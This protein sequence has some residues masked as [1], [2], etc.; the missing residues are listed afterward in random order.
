MGDVTIV[1]TEHGIDG[2]GE[3]GKRAWARWK[4]RVADL[5]LG[6]TIGFSYRLPRSPKF[7]KLFFAML[8]ALT[9]S[10][11]QFEQE[12]LR[13]WLIVGAGYCDFVPGP[14]GRMVA[15]PKSMKWESMDD[16]EFREL[17]IAI[18]R[19]IRTEHAQ[20]FLWPMAT[21]QARHDGVERLLIGWEE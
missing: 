2:L 7:H 16:D 8:G 21:P 17:V 11:E 9:D 10:Q 6:E 3:T 20:Q 5:E 13:A 15:L 18:W 4:Q 14:K 19:F 1:K 12:Q